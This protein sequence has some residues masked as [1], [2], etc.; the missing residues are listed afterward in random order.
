VCP[1]VKTALG[2][3]L[4]QDASQLYPYGNSGRQR[5]KMSPQEHKA[6]LVTKK[7]GATKKSLRR[8]SYDLLDGW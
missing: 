2:P 3:G 8:S 6:E 7:P 5:V 4:A 1:D